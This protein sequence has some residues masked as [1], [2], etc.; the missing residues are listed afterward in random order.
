[1]RLNLNAWVNGVFTPPPH[2][3]I[4]KLKLTI[5]LLL[6]LTVYVCGKRSNYK[7]NINFHLWWWSSS[8]NCELAP[9]FKASPG[10]H[11]DKDVP[12]ECDYS[13]WSTE[14]QAACGLIQRVDLTAHE[15]PLNT[16]DSGTSSG[17]QSL[18]APLSPQ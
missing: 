4:K 16:E 10:C 2:Y 7:C 17:K 14:K 6:L 1:M 11:T 13:T 15:D 3:S 12:S 8:V 5:L 9:V 18:N